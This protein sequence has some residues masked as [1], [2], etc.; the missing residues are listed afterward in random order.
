MFCCTLSLHHSSHSIIINKSKYRVY[1][2]RPICAQNSGHFSPFHPIPTNESGLP[3]PHKTPGRMGFHHHQFS[4]VF[5][6][7]TLGRLEGQWCHDMANGVGRFQHGDGDAPRTSVETGSQ[8][9]KII[10]W[11]VLGVK[12][13]PFCV[14]FISIAARLNMVQFAPY[15]Y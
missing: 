2:T 9:R 15:S 6:S 11:R 10:G 5:T 1:I 4:L 13:S 14:G 7:T 12:I 3:H 8:K